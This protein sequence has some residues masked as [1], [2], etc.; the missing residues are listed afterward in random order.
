MPREKKYELDEIALEKG[1]EVIRLPPYQCKYNPIEL[2]WAQVKGQVEKLNN[3]FKMVDIEALDTVTID[4]W[5]KCVR[6]A[7]EIQDEDSKR[8]I[9]RDTL[10]EPIIMTILP[11]DSDW[12]DEEED[13]DEKTTDNMFVL[14]NIKFF[15]F[16]F[17]C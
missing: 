14:I 12:S 5:K 1:H 4:D 10:I 11:D 13:N 15:V 6:H 8:E 3:T 2:I 7:E 17:F 9:M 16:V